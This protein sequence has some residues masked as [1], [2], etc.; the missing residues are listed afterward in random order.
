MVHFETLG[1]T[2]EIFSL[3]SVLQTVQSYPGG[4]QHCGTVSYATPGMPTSHHAL[5]N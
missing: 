2:C 3:R 4:I 5:P 1:D